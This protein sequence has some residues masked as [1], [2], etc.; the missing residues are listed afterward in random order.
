MAQFFDEDT[1]DEVGLQCKDTMNK[2]QREMEQKKTQ[3]T[4]LQEQLD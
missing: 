1:F 3:V 4:L 2:I